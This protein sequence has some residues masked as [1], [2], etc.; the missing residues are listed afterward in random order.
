[1]YDWNR[2]L[3]P[4]KDAIDYSKFIRKTEKEWK[5]K[6]KELKKQNKKK[7]SK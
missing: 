3:E 4:L 5:K 2:I 6:E 7:Q 1:M